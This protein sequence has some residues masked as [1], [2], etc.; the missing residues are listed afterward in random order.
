MTYSTSQKLAAEGLGTAVLLA[1]VVGC[2]VMGETL[3]AGNAGVAL[4]GITV[5]TGPGSYVLIDS[6]F[7]VA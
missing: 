7:T 6:S 3:A 5:A 4:L 2:G 1:V